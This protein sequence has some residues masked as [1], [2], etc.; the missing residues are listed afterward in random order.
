M[1]QTSFKAALCA[2]LVTAAACGHANAAVDP[3]RQSAPADGWAS[4][5]GGTAGGSA[6]LAAQVY[7]VSK[8]LSERS[9]T[10]WKSAVMNS[11]SAMPF[12]SMALI[13][14]PGSG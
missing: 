3:A 4:Q 10:N 1:K 12:G 6:A 5:A 7:T 8:P 2:A 14:E 11:G 13:F 9:T